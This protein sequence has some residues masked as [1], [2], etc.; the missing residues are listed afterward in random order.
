M[1]L[2]KA[3]ELD[4][5]GLLFERY[6]RVLFRFFYNQSRNR[7]S[8][9]D[10]VQS[11]FVRILK[12]RERFREEGEF[13]HWMFA[14]ARNLYYDKLKQDQRLPQ[15][16]VENWQDQLGDQTHFLHTMEQRE[17]LHML[18]QALD[19]LGPE[20]KEILVLSKLEG[21]PYKEIA[22]LLDCSE[23]TVKVR[24]YRALRA[25]KETYALMED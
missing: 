12:Y 18:H 17:S 19:R 2:V 21:M 7:E 14:I 23:G 5:L 6:H 3:G 24:V 11:V 1:Q 15:E 13:K 25:L 4:K 8:S 10:L 20:K 16:D 9:E 22:R